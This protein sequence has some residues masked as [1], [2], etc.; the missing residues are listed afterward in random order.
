M[1]RTSLENTK[2]DGA[3]LRNVDLTRAVFSPTSLVGAALDGANL[4][5][6]ELVSVPLRNASLRG[7]NLRAAN[8][9]SSDLSGASLDAATLDDA[10]LI[11]VTGLTDDVLAQALGVPLESLGGALT[12][13][14]IR[15]ELRPD[16][17]AA[18]AAAC[19]G[20]G[21]PEAATYPQG[22]FHPMV[23]L[24]DTGQV[25]TETDRAF[26]MGWEPMALRFAQLVACV[27]EQENTELEHCPYTLQGGG[28]IASITRIRH[29]RGIRVV[30]AAT[31]KVVLDRDFEGSDPD[32][33]PLFHTFSSFDQNVTFEGSSI[34]FGK[35]RGD[36]ARLVE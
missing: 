18:L 34:A 35:F 16:I 17:L 19:R 28:G 10:T 4:E 31:G 32:S 27:E 22:Q 3:D 15:L 5:D 12:E 9:S 24:T 8:L 36:L 1:D 29:S 21:V 2:L 14:A 6:L 13:R 30:E 20:G 11:G 25:G 7:V 33:C 23:I 26:D